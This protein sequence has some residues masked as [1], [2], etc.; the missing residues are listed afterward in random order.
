[1]PSGHPRFIGS[2]FLIPGA[3]TSR[4]TELEQGKYAEKSTYGD[5]KRSESTKIGDLEKLETTQEGEISTQNAD[6]TKREWIRTAPQ[7]PRNWPLWRK[8]KFLCSF[9]V[10]VVASHVL[11]SRRKTSFPLLWS[12]S[13]FGS[14][15]I[16]T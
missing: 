9:A 3:M 10:G 8:C 15:Q 16:Y 2:T 14:A 7:S 1:M 5:E 11:F 12:I 6:A 4:S 13:A